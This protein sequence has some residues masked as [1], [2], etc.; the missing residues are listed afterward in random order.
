MPSLSVIVLAKNVQDEIITALKTAAFADEIILIDTGSTDDTIK[1]S[2]PYVTKI[3]KT[4]GQDFAAWRNLGAQESGGDWLLYLDS[5]ERI[6]VGLFRE[7][8]SVLE[9]PK[10]SAYTI[11]RHDIMLGKYL[12]HWPDSRV[13]RLIKK[14]ALKKWQGKLHEQPTIEGSIGKLNQALVH[15][16]HK[17]IDEKVLNTLNWSHLEAEMIQ[18]SGHPKMVGWRFWRII[19]TEFWHRFIRQ[20]LWKDGTQGHIEIIYQIFSRFITYVRLW[21]MQQQPSLKETY[22][23]IDEKI[24]SQLSKK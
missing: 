24:L 19:A 1:V 4:T 9:N 12:K 21:E 18:K 22:K 10:H 14:S 11:P 2:R 20:G 16:T 7:I 15:L 13:L 5:D 3:V 17:N 8:K 23:H 6:P